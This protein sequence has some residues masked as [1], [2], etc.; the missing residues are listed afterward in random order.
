MK[1][2]VLSI[3]ET[4]QNP[5]IAKATEKLEKLRDDMGSIP[6]EKI[7]IWTNS[8]ALKELIHE[9]TQHVLLAAQNGGTYYDIG[10]SKGYARQLTEH[11]GHSLSL[12][13]A[14]IT[15]QILEESAEFKAAAAMILPLMARKEGLESDVAAERQ[16]HADKAAALRE[17]LAKAQAE[18]LATV[19]S[20]PSVV[21]AATALQPYVIQDRY[22]N[23][24]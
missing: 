9:R 3:I 13:D 6:T 11:G 15:L 18:A 5:F 10:N 19:H 1:A 8:E 17:S 24:A 4:L 2:S 22:S 7:L 21:A 20:H 23:I 14:V 12:A 16:I